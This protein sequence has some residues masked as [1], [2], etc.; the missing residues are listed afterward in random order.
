MAPHLAPAWSVP[1]RVRKGCAVLA[2][3]FATSKS[4]KSK[5]HMPLFATELD[6][7]CAG[8]GMGSV[9]SSVVLAVARDL[10]DAL[11]RLALRASPNVKVAPTRFRLFAPRHFLTVNGPPRGI[12]QL[13]ETSVS[14]SRTVVGQGR[15]AF[16]AWGIVRNS[17]FWCAQVLGSFM[18]RWVCTESWAK[19]LSRP[20]GNFSMAGDF[21]DLL[22]ALAG[23]LSFL[24]M[25]PQKFSVF[26]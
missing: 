24:S 16:T 9:P 26:L 25:C 14:S 8:V 18:A 2:G 20:R 5:E 17:R 1:L 23:R 3:H 12:V 7:V 19:T 15:R 22:V 21:I 11:I 4:A 10:P 13:Q 6:T